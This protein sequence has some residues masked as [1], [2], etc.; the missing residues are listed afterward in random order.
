MRKGEANVA[1][2]HWRH[3]RVIGAGNER[4]TEQLQWNVA[5]ITIGCEVRCAA[6]LPG[7]LVGTKLVSLIG[8]GYRLY[9]Q[10]GFS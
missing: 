4:L 8:C 9:K 1:A 7:K 10:T 6:S 2:I 5:I 3:H